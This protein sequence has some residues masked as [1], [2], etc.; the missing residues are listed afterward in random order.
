MP[1]SIDVSYKSK[2]GGGGVWNIN[3]L[4]LLLQI[5]QIYNFVVYLP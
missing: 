1:K 3:W 5:L 4:K 2:P